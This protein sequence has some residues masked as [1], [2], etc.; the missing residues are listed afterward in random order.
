VFPLSTLLK[1]KDDFWQTGN[2]MFLAKGP[3]MVTKGRMRL[4]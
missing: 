4:D 3:D 1:S 2:E